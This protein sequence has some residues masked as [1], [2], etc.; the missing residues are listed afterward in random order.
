MGGGIKGYRFRGSLQQIGRLLGDARERI[1]HANTG[2]GTVRAIHAS[3]L[4]HLKEK[5]PVA[6][7]RAAPDAFRTGDTFLL[8]NRVLEIGVFD[9]GSADGICRAHLV[10]RRLV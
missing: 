4:N 8:V 5:R 10:L 1:A 7:V 9:E 2:N 3:A 6:E